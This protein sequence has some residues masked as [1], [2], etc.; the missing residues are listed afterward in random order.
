MINDMKFTDILTNGL[1]SYSGGTL[2]F[3]LG[4]LAVAALSYL[5]GSVNFA[6]IFSRM[7][8]DDVRLYGSGNAGATNM[9]RTYGKKMGA[10]VFICDF[11]KSVLCVFLGM[12]FMPADG[13][14]YVAALFC[15]IGHSFPLYFGFRGGKGVAVCVGAMVVLNP[16]A[17]I[18]S[19]I[20]YALF[21]LFSKYVSLSSMAMVAVFPILNYFLPFSLFSIPKGEVDLPSLINYVLRMMIPILW[22]IFVCITHVENIK[23][24][25]RGTETKAGEK[26]R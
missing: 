16:L 25:I 13:F 14:G 1:I 22:A 24:L 10:L 19:I 11:L 4:A 2:S 20:V 26:N 7:K 3:I 8:G 18:F 12:L 15:M 21:L 6:V 17:A 23:R 5:I 9:I